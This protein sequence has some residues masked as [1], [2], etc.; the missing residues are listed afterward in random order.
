M[1]VM[2]RNFL[3]AIATLTALAAAY[4]AVNIA[5]YDS[6]PEWASAWGGISAGAELRM[7]A[8]DPLIVGAA[9]LAAVMFAAAWALTWKRAAN[10]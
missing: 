4:L 5:A 8:G 2:G 7:W 10:A 6:S 3:A 9:V 1:V